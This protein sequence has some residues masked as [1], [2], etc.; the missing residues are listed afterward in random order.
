MEVHHPHHPSHK[1]KISEYFLE[2]FMLFFAVTLGFFAE[3]YREHTIIDHR[4]QENYQAIV[5][6]LKQDN[7]KIDSIFKEA[8]KGVNLISL[9]FM[10]YEYKK[11]KLSEKQL[12]DSI[13]NLGTIPSYT[14]LFINNTTFKNMQSSGLLSYVGNKDLKSKLSYYY[15]VLFKKLNDNNKL[16]DDVGINYFD[17]YLAFNQGYG[18][19]K[20]FSTLGEKSIYSKYENDFKDPK[21]YRRFL[22][23]LESTKNLVISDDFM[24]QTNVYITRYYAYQKILNTIKETNNVLIALLESER[25]H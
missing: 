2:F 24:H 11:D 1:K 18:S 22:I 13:D 17:K 6:D 21:T 14:T 23:H 3:N 20:W 19:R 25:N 10:L 4:M 16:F 15:E 5:V 8:E 9:S 12:I 7:N